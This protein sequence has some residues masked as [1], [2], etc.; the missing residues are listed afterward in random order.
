MNE[1]T[2]K[3]VSQYPERFGFFAFLPMPDLN[4][5]IEEARYAL[6]VLGADGVVLLGNARGRYFSE[7]EFHP[8]LEELNSRKTVST[9]ISTHHLR[10][11]GRSISLNCCALQ[12]LNIRGN[13]SVACCMLGFNCKTWIGSASYA[14]DP[15]CMDIVAQ[16]QHVRL[17]K[18]S[19]A[20]LLSPCQS[21]WCVRLVL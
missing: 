19:Q 15:Q 13:T 9:I 1:Y 16:L 8:L 5:S 2:A 10:R 14:N 12:M 21:V 4:A 3:I 18:P 17:I 20:P 6:D 11:K 7:A